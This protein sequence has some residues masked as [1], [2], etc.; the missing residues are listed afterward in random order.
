VSAWG[1]VAATPDKALMAFVVDA[2][3]HWFGLEVVAGD[4]ETGVY[5][6]L[7]ARALDGTYPWEAGPILAG[8]AA[9]YDAVFSDHSYRVEI[10]GV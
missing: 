3:A 9:S 2:G 5:L 7:Y 4:A 1:G 10:I 8:P 6:D